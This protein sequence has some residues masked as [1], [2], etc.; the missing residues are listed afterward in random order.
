HITAS[1]PRLHVRPGLLDHNGRSRDAVL[2]Q[3]HATLVRVLERLAHH[4]ANVEQDGSRARRALR[5][6]VAF[7][8]RC[9]RSKRIGDPRGRREPG[10]ALVGHRLA[11]GSWITGTIWPSGSKTPDPSKA[12]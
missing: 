8:G 7:A 12:P 11:M 10:L 9:D 6:P 3:V 4:M 5:G 1:P 2:C